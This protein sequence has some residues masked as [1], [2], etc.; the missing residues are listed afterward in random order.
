MRRDWQRG[1]SVF[2]PH[3]DPRDCRPLQT[4]TSDKDESTDVDAPYAI[5]QVVASLEHR[6]LLETIFDAPDQTLRAPGGVTVFPSL[7]G[8]AQDSVGPHRVN[9]SGLPELEADE[10]RGDAA[11]LDLRETLGEGGM[12]LVRL[13]IQRSLRREVAVKS[14]KANFASSEVAAEGLIREAMFTGYLE[15]PN[16]VPVHQLGRGPDGLPLLVMKRVEGVPWSVLLAEPDHPMWRGRNEDRLLANLNIF[17]EVCFALSFAH[18]RGIL[19][20]DIKPENV[21][22]GEFG[23]V[24]LVDWGLAMYE[25]DAQPTSITLGTPAYMAPEMLEGGGTVSR[26]T[27]VYL[28]G[29]TLHEV[30]TGRPPHQG[31]TVLQ[32]L[33][34]VY[35][36]SPLTHADS[37]PSELGAICRRAC[38]ADP[39]ARFADALSVR[40][41][42]DAFVDHRASNALLDEAERHFAD[43]KSATEEGA[44]A[45]V[46]NERFN[47][48]LF[49]YRNALANWSDN[50]SAQE[51]I[52]RCLEFMADRA[53]NLGDRGLAE[54]LIAGLPRPNPT[55][56]ERLSALEHDQASER[57]RMDKLQRMERELNVHVGGRPR[58]LVFFSMGVLT[59][60]GIEFGAY[61]DRVGTLRLSHGVSTAVAT[62]YLAVLIA[63]FLGAR[64]W[65]LPTEFSRRVARA[66]LTV[67]AG[68]VAIHTVSWSLGLPPTHAH[69]IVCLFLT[70][71]LAMMAATMDL[72][73]LVAV[74]MG[75]AVTAFATV[76]PSYALDAQAVG[77]GTCFLVVA[78]IFNSGAQPGETR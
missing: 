19:H 24:Y 41:A 15:H 6:G 62:V 56:D 74:P 34:S 13:A 63:L 11:E 18:S 61:S 38:Q 1:R 73:L 32:L 69:A 35:R 25:A 36:S 16:I 65:L 72:R 75:I 21:M 17:R 5:S 20:R 55:L 50:A 54:N 7:D 30:L 49:S 66:M 57:Q 8:E 76:V 12:G 68:V 51:G 60:I 48:A 44:D 52:Q 37:V 28:L 4:P 10:S 40:K 77:I 31:A 43:L 2:S 22:V 39:E 23:E 59:P 46:V 78:W 9:S 42:V 33:M 27:D 67:Q 3:N 64:K 58:A 14:L 70:C 26:Q 71:M 53:L 47:Q 45:V 29:A